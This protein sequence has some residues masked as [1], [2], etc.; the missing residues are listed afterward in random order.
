MFVMKATA[1]KQI[2]KLSQFN[3]MFGGRSWTGSPVNYAAQ[4]GV[5][6]DGG[7]STS[8]VTEQIKS[9]IQTKN[10]IREAFINAPQPVV[11]VREI[12]N[13]TKAVNKS[14]AVSEL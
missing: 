1:A 4:G 2:H 8:M 3:Q 11:S 6:S 9:D 7:F 12:T 14:V 10:A 5:V 13:V